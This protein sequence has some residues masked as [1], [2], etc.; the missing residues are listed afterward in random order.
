MI[1]SLIVAAST[2]NVIGKD[3]KLLWH[4]PNDMKYFRNTTWGMPVI[5]GRKTYD[6]LAGEPLPGRFNFVITRNREW[7]PHN[8]K[9]KVVDNLAAAVTAA[10]DT[11]AKEVFVIGGGEIYHQSMSIADKIY[12][13]RVHTEV[14][15]DTYFPVIDEGKWRLTNNLDFPVD[16]KHAYAYSFQ[17][18]ERKK[19]I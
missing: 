19:T 1:I 10:G 18:W 13:T 5:M 12:M 7:D 6:A 9:V 11:D 15:G 8:E 16:E 3:N 4:L 17:V 2:N 14:E